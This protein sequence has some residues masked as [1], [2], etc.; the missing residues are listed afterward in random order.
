MF[1]FFF[2][3]DTATTEIYTLSLHDALPI[4]VLV[5]EGEAQ[6]GRRVHPRGAD[7][8]PEVQVRAGR[9]TAGPDRPEGLTALD[10]LALADGHRVEVEV[11]GVETEAVVEHDQAPGE[12]EFVDEGHA[13]R[14]GRDDRSAEGHRVIDPDVPRAPGAVDN[15][16][17]A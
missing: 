9:P 11:E 6:E 13:A 10:T 7:L 17:G 8:G 12:E 3:N 5:A 16:P 2:F 14:V 4:Y 15:P 1:F